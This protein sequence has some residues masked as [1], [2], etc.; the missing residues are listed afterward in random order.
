MPAGI[1]A[2]ESERLAFDDRGSGEAA[3]EFTEGRPDSLVKMPRIRDIK[4]VDRD[5]FHHI[6]EIAVHAPGIA[7]AA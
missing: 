1:A 3:H 7:F 4:S 2:T 6:G 5:E